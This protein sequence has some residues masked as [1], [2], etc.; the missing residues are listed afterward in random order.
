MKL[1]STASMIPLTM[2][3]FNAI[4]PFAPVS[5]TKGYQELIKVRT[6][7]YRTRPLALL[8]GFSFSLAC[9]GARARPLPHHRLRGRL[10][11]AQLGSSGRVCWSQC[12]Q[13]LPRVDRPG[14]ARHLSRS[15][16]CSRNQPCCSFAFSSVLC[17]SSRLKLIWV[18]VSLQSAVMA[19][20]KVVAVKVLASGELDME[21]LRAKA[22][23]HKDSL[24][25]FMVT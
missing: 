21:D 2:P 6:G 13:G 1:N 15:R 23:K 16:L 9:S 8:T 11:A 24:A 19:G 22:E 20:L 10:F 4:H 14:Q 5:Q 17:S 18:S 25:A 3:G 12:H 7:A